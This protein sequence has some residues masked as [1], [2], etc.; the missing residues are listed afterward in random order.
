MLFCRFTSPA[1]LHNAMRKFGTFF[2]GHPVIISSIPFLRLYK[3]LLFRPW[4]EVFL[5]TYCQQKY[6]KYISLRIL[7][8]LTLISHQFSKS[9]LPILRLSAVI[10]KHSVYFSAVP[11]LSCVVLPKVSF[12]IKLF[13]TN[14]IETLTV[15]QLYTSVLI[16]QALCCEVDLKSLRKNFDIVRSYLRRLSKPTGIMFAH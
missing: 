12:F 16:C 3:S 4:S 14:N 11:T 5:T 6:E 9:M 8:H 10:Y 13:I 2:L 1:L 15:S 7:Y